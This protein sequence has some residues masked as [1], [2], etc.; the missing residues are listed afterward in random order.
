MKRNAR[1]G[2]GTSVRISGLWQPS[3]AG[4]EQASELRAQKV[5]VLGAADAEVSVFLLQRRSHN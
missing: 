5:E 3:P 1:L 4:K 2:T